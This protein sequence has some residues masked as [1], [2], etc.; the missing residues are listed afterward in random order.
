MGQAKTRKLTDPFYGKPKRPTVRGLI[1]SPP[2]VINGQDLD[3][4]GTLN[5]V[6]LRFSLMFWDRLCWPSLPFDYCGCEDALDLEKIGILHRP[7]IQIYGNVLNIVQEAPY[8][9]LQL[10]EESD[11]GVWAIGQGENAVHAQSIEE[12]TTKDLY[13]SLLSSV[14][15]PQKSVPIAEILEFKAKRRSEL[16]AFRAHLDD[17]VAEIKGSSDSHQELINQKGKL[18]FACSD[19]RRVAREWQFPVHIS[20]FSASLDYD[21]IKAFNG[22]SAGWAFEQSIGGN[23]LTSTLIGL[24]GSQFKMTGRPKFRN[25]KL[26]ASPYKYAYKLNQEL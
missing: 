15:I 2:T 23:G 5:P 14:P 22:G 1:I 19:L 21:I 7:E 25:P 20:D 17:V 4:T 3:I 8:R 11:P 18:E 24:T 9:A 16:L 6:D 26:P 12:P 10:L 13:I